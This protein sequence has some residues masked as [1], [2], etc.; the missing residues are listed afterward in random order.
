MSRRSAKKAAG[1][2][3]LAADILPRRHPIT[4]SSPSSRREDGRVKCGSQRDDTLGLLL[5]EAY[6]AAVRAS[7]AHNSLHLART[8]VETHRFEYKR[9]ALE[10]LAARLWPAGRFEIPDEI[11]RLAHVAVQPGI[12]D[13]PE[14]AR[15]PRLRSSRVRQPADASHC[16][17]CPGRPQPCT[18]CS[19]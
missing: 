4:A 19:P 16:G 15:G 5:A 13:C 18:T 9:P 7:D 1:A 17:S 6:F 14:G 12:V 11:G 10:R 8:G 2:F 3:W